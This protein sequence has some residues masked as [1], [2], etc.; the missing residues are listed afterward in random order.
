MCLWRNSCYNIADIV[1]ITV[2]KIKQVTVNLYHTTSDPNV[3][4]LKCFLY[5]E[6]TKK[7]SECH[8]SSVVNEYLLMKTKALLI[9]AL[10]IK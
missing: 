4:F 7:M 3:L 2:T 6:Q 10:L 5:T 1:G 9:K 8:I